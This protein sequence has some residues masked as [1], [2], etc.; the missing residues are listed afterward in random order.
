MHWVRANRR[1]WTWVAVFAIMWI[2]AAPA[3]SH[4]IQARSGGIGI[5]ICSSLG[6]KFVAAAD[7]ED[8]QPTVPTSL[9]NSLDHCPYCAANLGVD[10]PPPAAVAVVLL[11]LHFAAPQALF[12]PAYKRHAWHHAPSRAPP[13]IA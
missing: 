7:L 1:F 9:V 5:A 3:I 8:P 13:P 6:P 11:P 10:A 2:S 4:A 12:E